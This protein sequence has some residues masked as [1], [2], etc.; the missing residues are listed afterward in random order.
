MKKIEDPYQMRRYLTGE[1]GRVMQINFS[2]DDGPNFNENDINHL[3][4]M[5]GEMTKEDEEEMQEQFGE[6]WDQVP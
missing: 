3:K 4:S 6:D 1:E 2:P 5:F